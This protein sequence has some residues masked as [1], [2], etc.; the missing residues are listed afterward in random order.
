MSDVLQVLLY[1]LLAAASPGTLVATLAVL[2]TR[3]ARANGSAFAV[4]FLLGQSIALALVLVVGSVT[5]PGS[6]TGSASLELAVGVLLLV[7]AQRARRPA[8]P[9]SVAGPSRTARVLERLER[10]TPRTAFSFGVTLGVG[11]KR[12]VITVVAASAIA[13]AAV[14]RPEMVGLGALYVAVASVLVWVPVALYLV[15]GERADEAV[16]TTKDKL[17]GNQRR[18]TFLTSAVFGVFFVVGGLVRLL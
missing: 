8:K 6:G 16:A 5:V 2:G 4:G 3:R 14:S 18:I 12:L 15:A 10:V 7:A 17:A 11:V 13:L 9:P 1:G